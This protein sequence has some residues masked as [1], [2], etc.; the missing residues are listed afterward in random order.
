MNNIILCGFMGCGKTSVGRR[1][2]R[3]AK[4][5][6]IDLDLQLEEETGLTVAE[7]FE[8]FGVARFRDLE[9]E[10]IRGLARRIGCVVAT[11]GG[12]LTFARNIAAIDRRDTVVFLDAPFEVCYGRIKNSDRPLVRSN[13]PEALRQ[14]FDTR[15]AAYLAAA[16]TAV[17]A[18][19]PHDEVVSA[20]LDV[21]RLTAR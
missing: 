16:S 5:E 18:A 20:L 4:R 2:A 19:L 9:H 7:L 17:D 8:R 12:A 14:L 6:Y 13:T 1:F 11:G 10:A 21:S 3:Q 15:R